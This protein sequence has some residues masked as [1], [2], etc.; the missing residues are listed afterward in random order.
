MNLQTRQNALGESKWL[1]VNIQ[2]DKEFSCHLM[3]RDTWPNETVLAVVESHYV[4]WQR[5]VTS[6][7]G[8]AF[9]SMHQICQEPE[10]E[11]SLFPGIFFVDPR[12]GAVIKSIT[13]RLLFI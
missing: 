13:A 1:L 8:R 11:S 7:G 2:S 9:L 3:N 4:F 10:A 5:G 12:T 6:A